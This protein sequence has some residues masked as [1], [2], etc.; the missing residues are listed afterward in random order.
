MV[1][2]Y[3]AMDSHLDK[4][5]IEQK[6]DQSKDSLGAK[7]AVSALMNLLYKLGSRIN[8]HKI[9]LRVVQLWNEYPESVPFPI[10]EPYLSSPDQESLIPVNQ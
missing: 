5:L 4:S 9:C 6:I 10:V 8:H 3:F 1:R 7:E 2:E